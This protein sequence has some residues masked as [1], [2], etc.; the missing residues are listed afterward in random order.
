M[1]RPDNFASEELF[2]SNYFVVIA[3]LT[4]MITLKVGSKVRFLLILNVHF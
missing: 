1:R 4:S 3:K 2:R